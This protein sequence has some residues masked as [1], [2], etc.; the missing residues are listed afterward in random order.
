MEPAHPQLTT[1][2]KR[3]KPKGPPKPP[4]APPARWRLKKKPPDAGLPLP[5]PA[6]GPI[7]DGI[8]WVPR[9]MIGRD[10]DYVHRE[11]LTIRPRD[12]KNY[13]GSSNPF[14]VFHLAPA[15]PDPRWKSPD[16]WIGMPA[17]Y[18][19]EAFGPAKF[20]KHED[21]SADLTAGP[22]MGSLCPEYPPQVEACDTVLEFMRERVPLGAGQG[23]LQL[24]CGFGKTVCATWIGMELGKAMVWFIHNATLAYNIYKSLCRFAPHLVIGFWGSKQ[25]E[26]KS[27]SFCEVHGVDVAIVYKG[28]FLSR[29]DSED[30]GPYVEPTAEEY[31]AHA[32]AMTTTKTGPARTRAIGAALRAA[33]LDKPGWPGYRMKPNDRIPLRL[34]RRFFLA[35]NDEAHRLGSPGTSRLSLYCVCRAVLNLTATY[36][37]GDGTTAKLPWIGGP[38]IYEAKRGRTPCDVTFRRWSSPDFHHLETPDG[39]VL[40]ARMV[41]KICTNQDRNQDIVA[42]IL[43]EHQPD[44]AEGSDLRAAQEASVARN[45]SD[46]RHHHLI[47]TERCLHIRLLE[48]MLNQ[49]IEAR[50]GADALVSKP[51]N[52]VIVDGAEVAIDTV[53]TVAVLDGSIDPA[54]RPI[55]Y[56]S[57]III[58]TYALSGDGLDIFTVSRL[59]LCTP[60]G[61]G[62]YEQTTGRGFRPCVGKPRP[63]IVHYID[64]FSQFEGMGEG[65]R[66]VAM[67]IDGWDVVTTTRGDVIV[68]RGT[69]APDGPSVALAL[70]AFE[71]SPD[72]EVH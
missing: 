43:E 2:R 10:A 70:A 62:K 36:F 53:P 28:F 44:A 49:Q 63:C 31:A 15:P 14:E 50:W 25:G 72:D 29:I 64:M 45:E 52:K 55:T 21:S 17:T 37:R 23:V 18:A 20:W 8:V 41:K 19:Y 35:F 6:L 26:P 61:R 57:P 32:A 33:G 59:F 34:M 40:I 68:R 47:F 51:R 12:N 69:M 4:P 5:D 39:Q 66:D 24:P 30:D 60:R 54:L 9:S 71:A 11:A 3:R 22:F 56:A 38:K 7:A 65:C 48:A 67:E 16:T 42:D 27:A 1:R 46:G 13:P 58:T